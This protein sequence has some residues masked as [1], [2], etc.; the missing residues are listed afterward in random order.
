MKNRVDL[1]QSGARSWVIMFQYR[2]IDKLRA[3][4]TGFVIYYPLL[5]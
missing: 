4:K 1:S 5:V 3:I 2:L